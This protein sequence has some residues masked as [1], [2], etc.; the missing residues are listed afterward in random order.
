MCDA[1][2]PPG[3]PA[4]NCLS[5]PVSWAGN[6]SLPGR[7]SPMI[8][9]RPPD[10]IP[11]RAGNSG[12]AVR[13]RTAVFALAGSQRTNM[14]IFVLRRRRMD[15][16][17]GGEKLHRTTRLPQIG[18]LELFMTPLVPYSYQGAMGRLLRRRERFRTRR[19]GSV[20]AD[21]G[22]RHSAEQQLAV[23]TVFGVGRAVEVE[24]DSCALRLF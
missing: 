1:N 18:S 19:H 22:S 9:S 10:G 24:D 5:L 7:H 16:P 8:R 23:Y 13:T 20:A 3:V 4:Y 2:C 12:G 14:S 21:T 11:L 6:P 17:S 15:K